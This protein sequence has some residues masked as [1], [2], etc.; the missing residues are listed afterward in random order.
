VREIAPG[1]AIALDDGTTFA[2][3]EV[4]HNGRERRLLDRARWPA[5]RVFGRLPATI[6]CWP[7][8][9]AARRAPLRMLAAG[10]RWPI[11][12]HIRPPRQCGRTRG[13]GAAEAPRAHAFL[14]SRRASRHPRARRSALRRPES[15]WAGDGSTY[16][17][18][19]E[20]MLI[21]ME[22]GATDE[23]DRACRRGHQ[24]D[25]LSA[26]PCPARSAR[27]WGSVGNDGRV[28]G[29]QLEALAGVAEVIH[30]SK[31]YKQ[32]SRRVESPRTRSS[33]SRPA[34]PSAVRPSRSSR[35]LAR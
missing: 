34:S 2:R 13:G 26:R 33:P 7:N 12:S 24:G 28:D 11:P 19:E 31:P 22:H 29:S 15:P 6:R 21:V 5:G 9:R 17:I 1:E 25:G 23:Q 16:E 27:R 32:V 4:P 3:H 10:P 8:G 20:L 18:E 30:V 35:P 14:P